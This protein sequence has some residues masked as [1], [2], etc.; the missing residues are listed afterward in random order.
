M[1]RV[2][3]R[4]IVCHNVISSSKAGLMCCSGVCVTLGGPGSDAFPVPLRVALRGMQGTVGAA[5]KRAGS[6][7]P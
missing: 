4:S 1:G 2:P 3:V 5:C 6:R 7:W